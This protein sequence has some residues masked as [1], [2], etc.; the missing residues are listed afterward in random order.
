MQSL[1]SKTPYTW[2]K[3]KSK[4]KILSTNNLFCQKIATSAPRTF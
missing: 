1:K 2:E 4:I 3:L